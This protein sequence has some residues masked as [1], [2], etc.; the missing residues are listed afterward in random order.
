MP[1]TMTSNTIPQSGRFGSKSSYRGVK[2]ITSVPA[3]RRDSPIISSV[4]F[5][6]CKVTSV[7][8]DHLSSLGRCLVFQIPRC[9]QPEKGITK[10]KRI[11]SM[12]KRHVISF[13]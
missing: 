8:A 12:S 4:N 9:D 3:S 10:Q 13:R 1:T 7:L 6:L 11:L 2:T 5:L